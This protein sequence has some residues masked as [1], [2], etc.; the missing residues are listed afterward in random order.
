MQ[1]IGWEREAREFKAKLRSESLNGSSTKDL[2]E[3]GTCCLLAFPGDSTTSQFPGQEENVSQLV[4]EPLATMV[5]L[6]GGGR[7]K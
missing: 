2:L 5:I 1:R 3:N 4:D 6:M 7:C